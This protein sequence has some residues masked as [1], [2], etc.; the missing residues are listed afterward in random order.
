MPFFAFS[1]D[2]LARDLAE[3]ARRA[4]VR[5]A[6]ESLAQDLKPYDVRVLIVEPGIID[7]SMAAR[8]STD[9]EQ[10]FYTSRNRMAALFR[11]SLQHA[12]APSL[13]A[14]SI[15]ALAS[16]DS[17]QLRHPVGPDAAPF[18]AWRQAMSDEAWVAWGA[19]DDDAW[20]AAVE[21]DFGMDARPKA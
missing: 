4:V 6:S 8:I 14:D 15:V 17:S 19:L 7:T 13:V 10:S 2:P 21:A 16:G 12:T 5:D 11:S 20:Y 3:I 18:I 1:L 9:S